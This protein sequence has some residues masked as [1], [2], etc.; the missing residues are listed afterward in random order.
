M[1]ELH[2]Q[3]NALQQQQNKIVEM[4]AIQLKKDSFPQPHVPIFN[5][6][7]KEYGPFVR[8]FESPR[9]QVV[10]KGSNTLSSIVVEM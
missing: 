4:L 10:M 9:P 6:D 2:Q 3:Q 7:P 8:M 5:G 1:L